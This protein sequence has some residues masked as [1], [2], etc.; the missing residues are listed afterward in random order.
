M[1]IADYSTRRQL[2]CQYL[3]SLT[4]NKENNRE[5]GEHE[6]DE[7]KMKKK[8]CLRNT[9]VRVLIIFTVS[10]GSV[11]A[12][13]QYFRSLFSFFFSHFN[14]SFYIFLLLISIHALLLCSLHSLKHL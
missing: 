3:A 10:Q 6:L 4:D 14:H 2:L 12:I 1:F 7:W 5:T 9:A 11:N 8:K 13:T